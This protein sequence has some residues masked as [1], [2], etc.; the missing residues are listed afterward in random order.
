MIRFMKRKNKYLIGC[1]SRDN[2]IFIPLLSANHGGN[3]K[4]PLRFKFILA[5]FG[6]VLASADAGANAVKKKAVVREEVNVTIDGVQELWRLEWAS[7]PVSACGPE[8]NDWSICPCEG[9]AYGESGDLNLI[10]RRAGQKDERLSLTD[11]FKYGDDTPVSGD[12]ILK[13]WNVGK[14]DDIDMSGSPAFVARVKARPAARIMHLED[15]DRDGRASEFIL[16]IGTLPCGKEMSI[17]VGISQSN[18]HLHAFTS[19]KNPRKPLILQRWQWEDLAQAKKPIKV[20]QWPCGDHG[21]ETHEDAVV[22]ADKGT[23][24]VTNRSFTCTDDGKRGTFQKSE[25]R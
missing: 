2:N 18:P 11:L 12:A 9:F 5:L 7:P 21:S 23:I 24:R 13:R 14:K 1:S 3:M 8:G 16:Q 10:R 4:S 15:Y 19:V 25:E 17:A 6:I 20:V 22:S